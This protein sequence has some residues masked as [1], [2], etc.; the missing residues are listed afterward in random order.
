MNSTYSGSL[1]ELK[2]VVAACRLT[3]EWSTNVKNRFY[4][5]RA[6]TGEVL[7]WWPSTGTVQFQGKRPEEFVELF[8]SRVVV[9]TLSINRKWPA[10]LPG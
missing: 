4:A 6:Q 9:P 2:A 1:D 5:F 7:N 3:G 8:C 10:K